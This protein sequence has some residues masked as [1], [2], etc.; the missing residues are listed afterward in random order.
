MV[1]LVSFDTSK[2]WAKSIVSWIKCIPNLSSFTQI[3]CH[4]NDSSSF[5]ICM[6]ETAHW[7]ALLRAV[8]YW[9]S[10]KCCWGHLSLQQDPSLCHFLSVV[11]DLNTFPNINEPLVLKPSSDLQV[12]ACSSLFLTLIYKARLWKWKYSTLMESWIFFLL[13]SLV[14]WKIASVDNKCLKHVIYLCK[15]FKEL[16]VESFMLYMRLWA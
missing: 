15:G 1:L 10:C 7:L 3:C 12:K 14:T 8:I 6:P 13:K 11:F 2:S 4:S 9:K 5:C 16:T